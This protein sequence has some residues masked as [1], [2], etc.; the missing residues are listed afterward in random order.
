ML[1]AYPSML[2]GSIKSSLLKKYFLTVIVLDVLLTSKIVLKYIK[3]RCGDKAWI[4]GRKICLFTG[5][6]NEG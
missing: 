5:K 2:T 1:F 4:V 6:F 3:V